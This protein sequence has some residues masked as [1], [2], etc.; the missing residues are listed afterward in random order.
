MKTIQR[1]FGTKE[2]FKESLFVAIAMLAVTAVYEY[3]M[4]IVISDFTINYYE[5]F[6]TWFILNAVW[7]VR[8][9]NIQNWLWGILGVLALGVFFRD[10]GL[11]GQQW[12]QWAFFLPV[13]IWSWYFWLVGGP[14]K[15]ELKVT[16]LSG[17]E[18]VVWLGAIVV[19]T[20]FVYVFIDK[21]SPGSLYPLLD[22]LVVVASMSAQFLMGRKKVESWVLWLGPVN[23]VS[24]VLFY[25]AGAYVLTALYIAF[26][27]HAIFGVKSWSRSIKME[28]SD[29][30]NIRAY[31]TA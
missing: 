15:E 21:L 7:L 25:L 28:N 26:F 12:L 14:R 5:F 24:I 11:P 8:T 22:A 23:M 13:Q 1:I 31:E 17:K 10:I 27:V 18:R 6:G 20:S 29:T 2:A 30:S 19:S 16:V 9:Q 4:S 3:S